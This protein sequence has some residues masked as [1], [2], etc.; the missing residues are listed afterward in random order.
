MIDPRSGATSGDWTSRRASRAAA[1]RSEQY[2]S[3][4]G[5]DVDGIGRGLL[6]IA[7]LVFLILAVI[8][9]S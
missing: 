2:G 6:G 8:G 7:L 3:D 9:R 1:A 5:A 4:R